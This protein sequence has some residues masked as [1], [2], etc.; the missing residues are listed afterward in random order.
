MGNI[1]VYK[2]ILLLRG[3]EDYIEIP[4]QVSN[5]IRVLDLISYIIFKVHNFRDISLDKETSVKE[6]RVSVSLTDSIHTALS[7][8]RVSS[9]S[10]VSV[11]SF[12]SSNFGS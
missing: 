7:S 12:W 4:N 9:C 1:P 6:S 3:V 10:R 11:I 8:P 2:T 5:G